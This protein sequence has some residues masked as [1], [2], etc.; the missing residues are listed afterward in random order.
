MVWP[1]VAVAEVKSDSK[2]LQSLLV[3]SSD[4]LADRKKRTYE[5]ISKTLRQTVEKECRAINS[6]CIGH[7]TIYPSVVEVSSEGR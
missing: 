5:A 4:G 1:L 3:A 7:F 6:S 2:Y